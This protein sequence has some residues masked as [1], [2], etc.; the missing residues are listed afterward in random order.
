M[1][2][3]WHE[4]LCQI[5]RCQAMQTFEGKRERSEHIREIAL[6]KRLLCRYYYI[7]RVQDNRLIKRLHLGEVKGRNKRGRPRRT[8][9]DEIVE[10][11]NKD[12][13][14]RVT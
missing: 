5:S 3:V 2:P 12:L 7:C 14:T 8:C 10:W 4:E 6:Y 1:W 11:R 9:L 13:Y